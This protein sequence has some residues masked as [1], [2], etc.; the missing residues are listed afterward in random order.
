[1]MTARTRWLTALALI[2]GLMA[3]GCA[4]VQLPPI[5][6]VLPPPASTHAAAGVDPVPPMPEPEPEP[7]AIELPPAA[8]LPP[9]VNLNIVVHDSASGIGISAAACAV[10]GEARKADGGGFINFAVRGHVL[11]ACSAPGYVSRAGE[12]EPGDRRFPLVSIEQPPK[13]VAPSGLCADRERAPL[14]CVR[15]VAAK[16]P[17]LLTINTYESCVEFT[18]RVLV[19]LGPDWG[20]VGKTAGEGQSV[21]VGFVP[22][23]VNGFWITGVSHDAIKHR[24]TGQVVDLLGN[25]SANSDSDPKIHGPASPMWTLIPAQYWRANNPFV[26]AVP[27]R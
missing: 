1:M 17:Q 2:L 16:F 4:G 26:P 15:Q 7:P 5:E 23:E 25:A 27:V 11:A 18:Q 20:H 22:V 10:D 13:P 6:I 19:I 8:E 12:L 3:T 24:V 21:P 14:E 9:L